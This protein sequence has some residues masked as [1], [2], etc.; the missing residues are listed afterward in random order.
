ML[1]RD[2]IYQK[3]DE[4]KAAGGIQLLLQG[5]HHHQ[6][7]TEWFAELF[8][9]I[10]E[11]YPEIWIHGMSPPE[12]VHL[13]HLDKKPIF[14]VIGELIEAGLDSI[15][16]GGAEILVERVSARSSPPR[17]RRPTSGST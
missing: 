15:P 4:L 14:D 3:I 7:K 5:G 9:D 11:R 1:E 10:K 13:S 8:R 6:L 2:V 17:R 16:G 12:I